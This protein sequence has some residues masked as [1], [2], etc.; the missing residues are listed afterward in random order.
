M[1][2]HSIKVFEWVISSENGGGSAEV[3]K[4]FWVF[5]VSFVKKTP[6]LEKCH[7]F[8]IIPLMKLNFGGKSSF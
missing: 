3:T 2:H 5:S 6:E 1:S 8:A 4:I 7:F